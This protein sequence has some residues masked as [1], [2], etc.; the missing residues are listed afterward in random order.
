[1]T[2]AMEERLRALGVSDGQHDAAV[3]GPAQLYSAYAHAGGDRRASAALI[4]EGR[5]K[6]RDL[7]SRGFDVGY[8]RDAN[9]VSAADARVERIYEHARYA[10]YAGLDE[11]VLRDASPRHLSVRTRAADRDDYLAHPRHG[12]ELR[13]D[14][15]R[16]V[17]SVYEGARPSVQFVISDGLNANAFNEHGRALL[18]HVR[19]SLVEA[20]CGI[21]PHDIVIRNG[22]VRAGYHVGGLV[23][24]TLVIH[25]IGERPGTGLNTLSAYLTYGLDDSGQLRW[26]TDLDHACTT[27]I[28]GIHPQGLRVEDAVDEIVRTVHRIFDRRRSGV[29]LYQIE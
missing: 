5:R 12:E 1:M 7:R 6:I 28:C 9:G 27:A 25:V 3:D 2:T 19:R 10:L 24:A 4:E 22:R 29:S 23:G 8:A 18:P 13:A 17:G 14:D 11:S 21:G 26:R 16:V 15:V 20:G